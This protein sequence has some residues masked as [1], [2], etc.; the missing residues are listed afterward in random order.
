MSLILALISI[1]ITLYAQFKITST[2]N[3]YKNLNNAGG[4]TGSE[5]ARRI[6]LA[7]GV[8]DVTVNRTRGA[9][10]S[11]T[12]HFNPLNKTIN[13]SQNVYDGTSIVSV[14][15]A[16][17]EVGHA[18]QYATGYKPV[19]IRSSIV[20]VV[21]ISS[22]LSYILI[23]LGFYFAGTNGLI[24]NL[25]IALFCVVVVFQIITLPVEFNASARALSEIEREGF[26]TTNEM[27][28]AKDVL[29][30]AAITYVAALLSAILNLLRL[31]FIRNSNRD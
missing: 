18:I 17:H 7:N 12:D 4:Y 9:D 8:T 30:A 2:V 5:V 1:V 6:L 13:L 3:K 11:L 16:A 31:L 14:A 10:W 27:K 29:F 19:K 24:F 23:M 21:N 15:V 28:P 22:Y 26:L 25:G 20:P